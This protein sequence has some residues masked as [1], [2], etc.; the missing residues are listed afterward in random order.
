LTSWTLLATIQTTSLKAGD[1][2]TSHI[3][4]DHNITTSVSVGLVLPEQSG[5]VLHPHRNS[6]WLFLLWLCE[7][8][9]PRLVDKIEIYAPPVLCAVLRSRDEIE[10]GEMVD[11]IEVRV[12]DAH[13]GPTTS[14]A[15]K[16]TVEDQAENKFDVKIWYT[17]D[18]DVHIREG[19]RYVLHDGRGRKWDHSE[20]TLQSTSDFSVTRPE[21]VVEL[22]A[23]GD[24]HIGRE[25]RPKNTGSPYRTARQFL[26]A[27]GYAARYDVDAVVHAGDCFDDNPTATDC[28]IA[29]NGF[30]ILAQSDIPFLFIYGNHG[31]STAKS[32]FDR[33]TDVE[34]CHLGTE[35]ITVGDTIELFGIDNG[36]EESVLDAA[37]NFGSSQN[38]GNQLLVVHNE[39]APPRL[40]NGVSLSALFERA[41]MTFDCLLAGHIHNCESAESKGA[42][43]QHLGS[44]A[45]LSTVR[46]AVHNSAWL[47]R[48]A[49]G[50]VSL[51][52]ITI[53]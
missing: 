5:S 15:W 18:V 11:E 48:V 50:E 6:D 34:L 46:D 25:N 52:R 33:L 22:L 41:G 23:L 30:D 4:R 10:D 1:S 17:H 21:G 27:M 13:Q 35:G 28:M 36:S 29:E 31:V 43:I 19:W 8:T 42:K 3:I 16:L 37:S 53:S 24:S 38:A 39:I 32:F 12:L 14:L 40:K 47:V 9:S 49:S 20:I 26:T 51:Q 44:T 45:E 2:R 7:S